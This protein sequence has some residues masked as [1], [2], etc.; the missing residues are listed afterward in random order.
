MKPSRT[1]IIDEEVSPIDDTPDASKLGFDIPSSRQA[2]SARPPSKLGTN[3]KPPPSSIPL[4]RREKRRN[5][6]AT[7][8]ANLVQRKAVG[9]GA[10]VGQTADVRWDPY[11]GNVTTS[12]KDR[13]Q[14]V[15]PGEFSPPGSQF[16]HEPTG[17]VLGN[18]SIISGPPNPHTTI[19]DRVRKL[20]PHIAPMEKPAW[21]GATGRTTIVSPVADQPDMPPIRIPR[22][23]SK[24][25]T[26]PSPRLMTPVSAIRSGGDETDI[27][28]ARHA[29]PF[30]RT[31]LSPSSEQSPRIPVPEPLT[32]ADN[33]MKARVD[34]FPPAVTTHQRK[35]SA[36][37]IE[38]NFREA[39]QKSFNPDPSE[40]YVQPPSRFSITTYATSIGD[41]SS[42]PSTDSNRP[43]MPPI[44]TSSGTTQD[45]PTPK[46]PILNRKRPKVGE[47]PKV[48]T[49]KAV[50]PTSPVLISMTSSITTKRASDTAKT[51]PQSP[52]ETESR[53]LISSLQAQLDNLANRRNNI[54]RSIRQMTELMPKDRIVET[55]EVRRKRDEEKRK[56]EH[57]REEEA[58]IRQ[59]EHE[60]GLKLHR[61]WKR[62]DKDAV[63]EPTGLWVRRVTG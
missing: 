55:T 40:P 46:T 62:Q 24:R 19:R 32:P 63:Y 44:P 26:S 1:Q 48:T 34:A 20:K 12:N 18:Q 47:S 49:R 59:Q 14:S 28:S 27:A 13:P 16:I 2:S 15:E 56:V 33:N 25:V 43:P 37:T 45:S 23:S 60:L 52:A 39:L 10:R 22:K 36:G 35:D 11:S 61:A 41:N 42:R 50:N 54:T 8:A 51:L 7:T 31:V 30:A 57:L 4:L 58:D 9:D 5:Q 38:R 53:D 3:S 29:E 6:A 21:K 17:I